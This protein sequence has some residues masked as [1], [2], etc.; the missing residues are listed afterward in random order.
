MEDGELPHFSALARMGVRAVNARVVDPSLTFPVHNSLASGSLPARTGIVSNAY[1]E[2]RDNFYWY[3]E[4]FEEPMDAAEPV[5]VTASRA[6]LRAATILFPAG[7]TSFPR[8]MADYTVDYGVRDAYSRQVTLPLTPAVD[9]QNPPPS[10][11]PPLQG[12]YHIMDVG[13]VRLLA[14]DSTDDG[15]QNY[16]TLLL[17]PD[18][19]GL[20]LV[21]CLAGHDPLRLEVGDWGP[22]V[23]DP[24]LAA[25]ADFLLQTIT[26][27][28]VTFYHTGVHHNRAA[29]RALL[30][31]LN[32]RY[33]FFP[34]GADA[35]ALE[36]GWITEEDYLHEI[37][38]QSAWVAEVTA[39]VISD[40]HPDLLF[41]WQG[42]FDAAGHAFLLVDPR[43]EG[44]TSERARLY[45]DYYRRAARMADSALARMLEPVDLDRSAVFLVADHGMASTHTRVYVNTLLERAG[46][47]VLDRKDYVVVEQ[48]RAL[49]V[50][51]G[52]AVN[53]YLN[54]AGR[55]TAG[56]VPAG[57]AEVLQAQIVSLLSGLV[58][59]ETG[60]PVFGRVLLRGELASLGLNHPHSGDVFAQAS[61]G[62]LLDGY[63]GMDNI[64]IPSTV[65]GQH[66]YDSRLPEMRAL[67]IAA[68]AGL[69]PEGDAIPPIS[70]LDLAPTFA[71]LLG[72]DPAPTVDGHPIPD[73]LN[74]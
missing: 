3:R 48:S 21:V 58:D 46:L 28:E 5:W 56:I 20:G 42:N 17:C 15:M 22:L 14:A 2:P 6:G 50:A 57:E 70:I 4:A 8:Q 71:A 73:L 69:P 43:Q 53:I 68:G 64:F 32:A 25:G 72:F 9:L 66:G 60:E 37:E 23:L 59:P 61:P 54:L 63:R 38:R 13:W 36:H 7:L 39:W 62:Y 55:E 74:R 30:E 31:G 33:S 65:Y 49:A 52:A 11:S 67:F 41:A 51:S 18:H 45:A 1:H 26:A 34:S 19:D 35:Y 47:L 29:P 27:E 24:Q 16:D 40:Y 12:D 44:Y 10:F